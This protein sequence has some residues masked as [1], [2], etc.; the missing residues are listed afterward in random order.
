MDNTIYKYEGLGVILQEDGMVAF[1]GYIRKIT[2]HGDAYS[3]KRV[4]LVEN[5][6]DGGSNIYHWA[7]L[8]EEAPFKQRAKDVIPNPEFL[9]VEDE[10]VELLFQESV[11]IYNWS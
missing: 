6:G 7:Y 9:E 3:S 10:F 8:G 4:A 5:K 2:K 11:G 1:Q